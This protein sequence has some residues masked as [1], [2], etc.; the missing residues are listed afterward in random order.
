VQRQAGEHVLG[1]DVPGR[2]RV[3]A[4]DLDLHIDSPELGMDWGGRYGAWL[5]IWS[6]APVRSTV[7]LYSAFM[8]RQE[9]Q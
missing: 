1:E 7:D 2:L 9:S 4:L 8:P 5:Q 6:R 3:R